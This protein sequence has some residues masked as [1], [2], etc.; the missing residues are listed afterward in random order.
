[1][2][3]TTA[4]RCSPRA[5]AVSRSKHDTHTPM[6]G[7]LPRYWRKDATTPMIAPAVTMPA[8]EAKK[9]AIFPT[10]MLELPGS[11]P[12]V[13]PARSR[14]GRS[15]MRGSGSDRSNPATSPIQPREPRPRTPTRAPQHPSVDSVHDLKSLGHGAIVTRTDPGRKEGAVRFGRRHRYR[16]RNRPRAKPSASRRT[17]V[18]FCVTRPRIRSRVILRSV[19]CRES[20]TCAFTWLVEREMFDVEREP[21]CVNRSTHDVHSRTRS[22][23]TVH[24]QPRTSYVP[25][26]T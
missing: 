3:C 18:F 20:F 25:R 22:P 13:R 2:Y 12:A 6:L 26:S 7:G 9:E 14:M 16:Y 24:V 10:M 19:L 4:A 8:R 23:C 15:P 11:W 17:I 1:M 21:W 5:P